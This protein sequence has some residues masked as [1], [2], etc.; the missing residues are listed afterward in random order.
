M[1]F[2]AGVVVL[3]VILA[4]VGAVAGPASGASGTARPAAPPRR[5]TPAPVRRVA[6]APDTLA[7]RRRE[8]ERQRIADEAFFDGVLFSHYFLDGDDPAHHDS[9]FEVD[10][11]LD[12]GFDD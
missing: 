2:V 10:D 1:E 12:D 11:Y 6:A 9:G 5:S 8:L 7:A 4:I 3:V